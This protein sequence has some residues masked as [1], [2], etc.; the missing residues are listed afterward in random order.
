MSILEYL[1]VRLDVS[2]DGKRCDKNS[3]R[4]MA[5]VQSKACFPSRHVIQVAIWSK[6]YRL[7]GW[8]SS[9]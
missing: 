5:R 8:C 7:F 4:L 6:I 2:F 1:A 3:E 9:A